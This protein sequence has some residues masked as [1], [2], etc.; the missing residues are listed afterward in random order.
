MGSA[1]SAPHALHG[2]IAPDPDDPRKRRY[3]IPTKINV[4]EMPLSLAFTTSDG[5]VNWAQEQR[6]LVADDVLR[7]LANGTPARREKT[8][9]LHAELAD[10]PV[11]AAELKERAEQAG[12]SWEALKDH[13]SRAGVR[14]RKKS[15]RW[16]WWLEGQG[17]QGDE[18]DGTLPWSPSS[19]S[20]PCPP[21]GA[22]K[23]G[24]G[25]NGPDDRGGADNRKS[26]GV[27]P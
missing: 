1:S 17:D 10:G 18:G 21:L 8:E 7:Q 22:Q 4:A 20:S 2:W 11:S 5:K 27:A 19:S 12:I 15:G 6:E 14:S 9:F 23:R 26:R 24:S 25:G 13:K 16:W 3:L